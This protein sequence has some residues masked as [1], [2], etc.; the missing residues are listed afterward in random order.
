M[1]DY[2]DNMYVRLDSLTKINNIFNISTGSN[3]IILT[4]V[5]VKPYGFD[6]STMGKDLI[7]EKFYQNTD[8][9]NEKKTTPI[10]FYSIHLNKIRSLHYII[11]LYY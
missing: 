4:K 6:K 2:D 9:C 5:D 8:H 7:K 1:I 11:L 10:K 3:N